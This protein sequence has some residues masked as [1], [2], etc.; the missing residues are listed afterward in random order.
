[1]TLPHRL[2][3]PRPEPPPALHARASDDLRFI[4][5]TMERAAAFTAVPGWGGVLMGLIALFA[6]PAAITAS[7]RTGW[8]FTWIC[9]AVLA[10]LVGATD[11]ANKL[12]AGGNSM[13]RGTASR[14]ASALV[15]PVAAGA[16]LTLGLGRAGLF[17]ILPG[18]WLLCYGAGVVSAGSL[19][20]GAVRVMGAGFMLFGASA[21]LSPPSWGDAW[22]AAGFGGLHIIFGLWIA[23]HHDG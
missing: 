10:L 19:S 17:D 12:R 5:S 11:M 8:L 7:T 1:M 9:A 20:T 23:R 13:F 14:F 22:M 15:P 16:C 2:P 4:R 3:D 21:L 6:A 18:T